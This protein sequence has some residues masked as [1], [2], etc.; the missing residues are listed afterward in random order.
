MLVHHLQC[1]PNN[2]PTL[3][4]TSSVFIFECHGLSQLPA[5]IWMSKRLSIIMKYHKFTQEI[6]KRSAPNYSKAAYGIMYCKE[7]LKSVLIKVWHIPTSGFLLSRYCH[8]CTE[9]DVKQYSLTHGTAHMSP[10]IWPIK[11]DACKMLIQC[12]LHV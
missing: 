3:V 8:D 11:V 9:S 4:L 7:P 2:K 1:L 10:A 12:W 5:I 6:W